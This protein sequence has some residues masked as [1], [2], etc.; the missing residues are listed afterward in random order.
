MLIRAG[1][2]VEGLA[3]ARERRPSCTVDRDLARGPARLTTA[4]GVAGDFD[5]L[6]LFDAGSP[7]QLTLPARTA[8][9][10]EVSA[11]TGVGGEG[12]ATPWRFYLHGEPTVSPYRRA[13]RR[14]K[15]GP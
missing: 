14:P 11:R 4:L 13:A 6:D 8:S 7:L 2:V 5:G 15:V 3:A 12:A 9:A 1:E 10:V